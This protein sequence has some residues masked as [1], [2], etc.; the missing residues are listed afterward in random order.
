MDPQRLR[1]GLTVRF[2]KTLGNIAFGI[3][4]LG[5]FRVIGLLS[6]TQGRNQHRVESARD[7]HRRVVVERL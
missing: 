7:R 6:N 2:I 4:P 1:V 5:N 3:A